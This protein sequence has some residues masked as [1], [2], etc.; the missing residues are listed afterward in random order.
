M[1]PRKGVARMPCGPWQDDE[2]LLS[3]LAEVAGRSSMSESMRQ[4]AL[5][6]FGTRRTGGVLAKIRYDSLVDVFR[7]RGETPT[8]R[9]I[10]SFE[11]EELSVE[12]EVL[13]DRLTGQLVPPAPGRVQLM[14]LD[15]VAA[16]TEA[17]SLGRFS[18]SRPAAGPVR[19]RCEV[20]AGVVVT[21]WVRL[22]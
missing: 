11:A 2:D 19:F 6:A 1:L 7:W 15:G 3:E 9:R 12:V 20:P 21:D 22:F 18:L 8:G 16:E 14:T 10:L 5:A 17:D 13:G 4:A